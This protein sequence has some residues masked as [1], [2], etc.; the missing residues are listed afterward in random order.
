MTWSVWTQPEGSHEWTKHSEYSS[1]IAMVDATRARAKL[2]ECG[3]RA[4]VYAPGRHPYHRAA[5]QS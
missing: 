2:V 3:V 5:V 1:R 4:E